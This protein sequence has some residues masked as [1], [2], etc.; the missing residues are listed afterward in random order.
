MKPD[1]R[2]LAQVLAATLHS[3]TGVEVSPE[4]LETVELPDDLRMNFQ[5]VEDNGDEI[6]MGRHLVALRQPAAPPLRRARPPRYTAAR[7]SS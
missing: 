3:K 4:A 5:V 7:A 1:V 6:A 2:P